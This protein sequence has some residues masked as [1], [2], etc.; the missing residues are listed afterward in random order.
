MAFSR[1]ALALTTAASF[2]LRSLVVGAGAAFPAPLLLLRSKRPSK[3][4]SP[5]NL[6]RT[7]EKRRGNPRRFA[8]RRC[9]S[10]I[11]RLPIWS[12]RQ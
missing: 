4:H 3:A 1:K 2:S 12:K 6:L 10:N 11:R 9:G 5:S 8:F 7:K